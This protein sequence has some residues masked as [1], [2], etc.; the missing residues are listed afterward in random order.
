MDT[1]VSAS[2]KVGLIRVSMS[3]PELEV[4][5]GGLLAGLLAKAEEDTR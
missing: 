2:V 4:R 1:T 3:E 5:E